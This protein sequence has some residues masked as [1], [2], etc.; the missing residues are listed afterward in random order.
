MLDLFAGQLSYK[1]IYEE[2]PIDRLNDLTKARL[3]FIEKREEL[4]KKMMEEAVA[5]QQNDR[6][7]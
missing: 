3:R 7:R 2:I 5:K 6:R 1:E 4:Q